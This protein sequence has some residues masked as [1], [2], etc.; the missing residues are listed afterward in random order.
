MASRHAL[1]STIP[2]DLRNI[3]EMDSLALIDTTN[4]PV[5]VR[6]GP[7]QRG[8]FDAFPTTML[9]NRLIDT[10]ATITLDKL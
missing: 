10:I 8:F 5:V 7:R 2:S 9:Q 1:E 4:V 3:L 6:K